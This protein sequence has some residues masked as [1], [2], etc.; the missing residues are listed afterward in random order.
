MRGT[1]S[2]TALRSPG[3]WAALS[4]LMCV[5]AIVCMTPLTANAQ[6]RHGK[7]NIVVIMVDNLG[8]GDLGAYG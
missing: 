1:G 8:Y 6:Q 5:A 2:R 4:I 3:S 7:P